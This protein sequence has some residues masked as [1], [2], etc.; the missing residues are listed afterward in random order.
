M[1]IVNFVTCI[2]Q[3]HETT[4]K[5][6][7]NELVY[8]FFCILATWKTRLRAVTKLGEVAE[9]SKAHAWK[10]YIRHKRIKGS[11]PFLSALKVENQSNTQIAN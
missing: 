5:K 1:I 9:W 3:F 4:L 10:A 8:D 2:E 7:T 6:T 11:N